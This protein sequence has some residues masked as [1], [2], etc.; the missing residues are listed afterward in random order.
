MALSVLYQSCQ[1]QIVHSIYGAPAFS[2]LAQADASE[3]NMLTATAFLDSTYADDNK[4][5][6]FPSR[7]NTPGPVS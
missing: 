4:S 2:S 7:A 6:R 5:E 1:D 3:S